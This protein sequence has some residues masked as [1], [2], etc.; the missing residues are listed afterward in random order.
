MKPIVLCPFHD[1]PATTYRLMP[2]FI[3]YS[4]RITISTHIK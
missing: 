4:C 2:Y 1:A 3:S